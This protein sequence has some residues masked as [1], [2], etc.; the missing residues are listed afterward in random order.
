M[1]CTPF[2]HLER[3]EYVSGCVSI[4]DCCLSSTHWLQCLL[5]SFSLSLHPLAYCYWLSPGLL[6]LILDSF[7]HSYVKLTLKMDPGPSPA[8]QP[9]EW[10]HSPVY[11]SQFHTPSTRCLFFSMFSLTFPRMALPVCV[12]CVWCVQYV[13]C[14]EACVFLILPGCGV[15]AERS[16]VKRMG[17]PLYATCCFSLA[18][19]NSLSLCLV[20]VSLISMCLGIFLLQFI[21]YGTL[22]TS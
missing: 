1:L 21:L 22:C 3:M 8:R 18:A 16:A 2:H 20:F 6:G 4:W 10:G 11:L 5:V 14:Y 15:S 9:W 17:F 19:F 13:V 12:V 7:R